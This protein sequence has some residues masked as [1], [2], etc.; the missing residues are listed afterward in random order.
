[1]VVRQHPL[2][3]GCSVVSPAPLITALANGKSALQKFLFNL[4]TEATGFWTDTSHLQSETLQEKE[5]ELYWMCRQI[6]ALGVD[7]L[8][9]LSFQ[10]EAHS[11]WFKCDK[12]MRLM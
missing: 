3:V 8:T 11:W 10:S 5:P 9:L 6:G 12:V 2:Q 4:L 1:M 7:S